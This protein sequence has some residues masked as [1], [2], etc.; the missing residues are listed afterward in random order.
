MPGVTVVAFEPAIAAEEIRS[1]DPSA[2][3]RMN[4]LA[5][6]TDRSLPSRIAASGAQLIG[7][8][9]LRVLQRSRQ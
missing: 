7:F 3:A 8:A 9:A 5:V 1:I 2:T 4:D 6:L